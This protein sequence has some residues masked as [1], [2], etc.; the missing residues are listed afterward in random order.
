MTLSQHRLAVRAAH[1]SGDELGRLFGRSLGTAAHPRGQVMTAY[2][3]A[4]AAIRGKMG[5]PGTVNDALSTLRL[6]VE[7]AIRN[8]LRDAIAAGQAQAERELA[9]YGLPVAS[10]ANYLPTED[11]LAA[12]LAYLDAQTH[13]AWALVVSGT[14][15]EILI[16]GDGTRAGLLWPAPV[17]REAAR[18]LATWLGQSY[19]Q[20]VDAALRQ[21][22]AKEEYRRQA[23]ATIDHKT[24][25][26]C[27]RVHGQ[28]VGL[29]ESFKL[30]G[31]PR[32]ADRLRDPGFHWWCRTS[33]A[34]VHVRDVED[35]LTQQMRDAARDEL[36]ARVRTGKREVIWPSNARS[37]RGQP[38]D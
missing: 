38:V 9:A 33:I 11:A 7:L 20:M 24:T 10:G 13:A 19:G 34:L 27:L 22:G 5:Q 8:A 37:G 29:E 16:L 15:D 30:T 14:A 31:T 17:T 6:S 2:R 35:E 18:W 25:D 32:Y 3:T 21:A 36:D 12:V 26:C 1:Q 23:I 4:R 28:V